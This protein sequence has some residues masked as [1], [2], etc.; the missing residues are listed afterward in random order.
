MADLRFEPDRIQTK[1]YK[2]IICCLS[3]S[4]KCFRVVRHVYA[5]IIVS[6]R[7]HFKDPTKGFGLIQNGYR[8]LID[9]TCS[10]LDR[11]GK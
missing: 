1:D 3:E 5:P 7:Y 8:H 2:F 6:A 10:C 9:L 4:G 11:A